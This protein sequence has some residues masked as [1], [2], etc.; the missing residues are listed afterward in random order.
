MFDIGQNDL[1]G[2]FYH[3]TFDQVVVLIPTIIDIFQDG[4]KV[5]I[6]IMSLSYHSYYYFL[7]HVNFV[8]FSRDYTQKVQ[9]TFGYTTQDHL[10]V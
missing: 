9:E 6:Y 10:G 2:A 4:I 7:F 5:S 1:A 3:K 8:L